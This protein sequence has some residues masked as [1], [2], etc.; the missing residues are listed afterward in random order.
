MD[1]LLRRRAMIAAG[2]STPPTPLPY[3]PVEYIETDGSCYITTSIRAT[4]PKSSEIKVRI[5]NNKSCELL[6]GFRK[7]SGSD[8][9][10]FSLARYNANKYATFAFYATYGPSDG[11]PSVEWSI[12][13]D[14]PFI[15]KTDIKKGSQHI[16]VKQENSES[17]NTVSKTNSNNVSSSYGLVILGCYLDNA[18]SSF[19]SSGTRLYYCKIYT[20]E[21]YSTLA[22]DGIPCLYNGEYGLWDRVSDTFFGNAGSGTFS[23]PSNS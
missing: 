2:G 8:T 22:F 20:D 1:A 12:D 19:A 9:K 17:W 10:Q 21:T 16:S 5:G 14:K 4:P 23:G 15:I 7:S 3:T 13:N 6:S 18:Y 11:M